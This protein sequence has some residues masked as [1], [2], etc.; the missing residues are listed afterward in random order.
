MNDTLRPTILSRDVTIPLDVKA[1][2]VNAPPFRVIGHYPVVC[3]TLSWYI[4]TVRDTA[5]TISGRRGEHAAM[6]W[7]ADECGLGRMARRQAEPPPRPRRRCPDLVSSATWRQPTHPKRK[8]RP[9]HG[10]GRIS[11]AHVQ[12]ARSLRSACR[13]TGSVGAVWCGPTRRPFDEAVP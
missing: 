6:P 3:G 8:C 4:A 2:C 9:V 5:S 1:N 7:I 13:A 10:R 12:A 11:T